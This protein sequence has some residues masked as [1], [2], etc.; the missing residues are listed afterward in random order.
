MITRILTNIKI[1]DL[2]LLRNCNNNII[3]HRYHSHPE[4]TTPEEKEKQIQYFNQSDEKNNI[5]IKRFFDRVAEDAGNKL[6]ARNDSMKVFTEKLEN[7]TEDSLQLGTDFFMTALMS[8]DDLKNNWE[9]DWFCWGAMT[10]TDDPRL[11]RIL[12]K[13]LADNHCHLGAAVPNFDLN[14]I[15][16]MN[17]I[18]LADKFRGK[19]YNEITLD[20]DLSN[21]ELMVLVIL[22]R[23]FLFQECN[24]IDT[25]KRNE[26]SSPKDL[27]IDEK[28][29][30]I[31]KNDE[32]VANIDRC[33]C[34]I[35]VAASDIQALINSYR[36]F[37]SPEIDVGSD[38]GTVDYAIPGKYQPWKSE[39]F[40]ALSGERF[41][42]YHSFKNVYAK[43]ESTK[44]TRYYLA[45]LAIK[46]RI[47]SFFVQKN[48]TSGFQNFQDHQNRKAHFL[49]QRML[50][51][52]QFRI[53]LTA[54]Y[55]NKSIKLFEVRE[56][57]TSNKSIRQLLED[58]ARIS[59]PL[60]GIDAQV[61]R[62][63]GIKPE[64]I[65]GLHFVMAFKK[66]SYS[67]SKFDTTEYLR[68]RHQEK[69]R[70]V[71]KEALSLEKYFSRYEIDKRYPITGID[72][73]SA[74]LECPP[75]V[76]AQAYR[77]LRAECN[78]YHQTLLDTHANGH[79][80]RATFHVGEMF[81]D[82]INGLRTVFEAIKFLELQRGDRLGHGMV[83]G[84]NPRDFYR[85]KRVIHIRQQDYLDNIIW[86]LHMIGRYGLDVPHSLIEHFHNE[87]NRYFMA[88][89]K[90]NYIPYEMYY[91]AYKLRA[92]NPKRYFD[93]KEKHFHPLTDWDKYAFGKRRLEI[94]TTNLPDDV[95]NLNRDYHY[96]PKVKR[97]GRKV[98]AVNIENSYIQLAEQ[99]QK[100]M[101]EMVAEKGIGVECNL[102]SNLRIGPFNDYSEHPIF[103]MFAIDENEK[104]KFDKNLFV[105]INTDDP[106]VFNT[107]LENEYAVL[108]SALLNQKDEQGK[109]KYTDTQI[110]EWLDKVREMGMNQSFLKVD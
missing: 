92:D 19:E 69:R 36:I 105:S 107:T 51:T 3:V 83:L 23:L 39:P 66:S 4:S 77:F 58:Y 5:E 47:R 31:T 86:S 88:I 80:F 54:F 53:P 108:L 103:N 70:E 79:I 93:N 65:T 71:K 17:N 61:N 26:V 63:K 44:F 62:V 32:V 55:H 8:R 97:E 7:W 82:V 25:S 76:F 50:K 95:F 13:G 74:E 48:E 68:Y 11:N 38:K 12:E 10:G 24:N 40:F 110:Y 96:S 89:Y 99:L 46:H 100:K 75:E 41:L 18:S 1:C 67:L 73:L 81:L 85:N 43:N 20:K 59:D 30:I 45:Y 29:E 109:R 94:G 91:W 87:Y 49:R 72:A 28:Q 27:C 98:I 90:T 101:R 106:G 15:A 60:Q 6:N 64:L 104:H 52:L 35:P 42:M 16:M 33:I 37:F 9:R 2:I 84:I 14:W 57:F 56:C 102:T 22:L 34:R 78:K 21:K